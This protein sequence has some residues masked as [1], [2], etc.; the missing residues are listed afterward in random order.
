MPRGQQHRPRRPYKPTAPMRF[1]DV[2]FIMA[3]GWVVGAASMVLFIS[4][5]LR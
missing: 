3:V 2:A 4:W 5:R 1:R